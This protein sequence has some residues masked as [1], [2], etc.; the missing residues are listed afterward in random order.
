MTIISSLLRFNQ[1]FSLKLTF[2]AL[3]LSVCSCTQVK[4]DNNKTAHIISINEIMASNNSGITAQNGKLYDWIEI[5]NKSDKNVN[6]KDYKLVLEK[7]S[8]KKNN[9][10]QESTT[11][12]SWKCPDKELKPGECAIIF[13]SKK[14]KGDNNKDKDNKAKDNDEEMHA[15]FKLPSEGGKLSILF[16]DTTLVSSVE[17]GPLENDQCYRANVKLDSLF[18][19]S[20][21][22]TPGFDNDENGFE[23]YNS[24]IEHLRQGPL[25]LWELH[26]KGHYDNKAWVEIKNVSN[27]PVNLQDYYLTTSTKDMSRWQLPEVQLQ[28]G[29]VYLVNSKKGIFKISSSKSVM[30]TKDSKFVDGICASNAPAG[31]S[32]GRVTGK[33]GLFYFASP[34][35]GEENN[36]PYYRYI[37]QQPSFNTKPGVY[38]KKDGMLLTLDTHGYT[39][40][41]TTDGSR[42]TKESPV[43][44]D[45]IMINKT[46]IVRAFCEGDSSHIASNTTFGTF[47]IDEAHTIPVINITVDK[48]DLYDHN[49]GIYAEGPGYTPIYPHKGANYWKR[50]WKNAH[51][52]LFDNQGDCD[53][54]SEDCQLAIFGGFSRF[55]P[56]K[57]F[58]IRFKNA[59]GPSHIFYDLF[60]DGNPIKHKNFVLRSGSQDISGTMIR[61]EYFTSLM[62]ENSPNLLTQAYRPAALYINGEYFG[63]YYIREKIDDNYVAR[64]LNVSNDSITIMMSGLYCDQGSKTLYNQ[65]I[66]YVTGHDM[67]QDEFYNQVKDQFDLEGLIDYKLG[68]IYSMKVDAGNVRYVYSPDP[69]GDKKWHVVYYDIDASWGRTSRPM[70]FYVRMEGDRVVRAVNTLTH[71]L[72]KNDNFRQ[73]FLERLSHHMH[74]T[75]TYDN[76]TT[77]FDNLINTI[78]PEMK[79][80]CERWASVMSYNSWEKH[81]ADFRNKFKDRDK[82]VLNGLRHELQITD[83]ENK[84][85]FSDLGF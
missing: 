7:T 78:K 12:I 39:V 79:R 37:A 34:T 48:A 49:R 36:A 32:V 68:E 1:L 61:D 23:Q 72:L 84:K 30:L 74:T 40:H 54:F 29:E 8:S 56:K 50:W 41:Y 67:S 52:E 76:V 22:P 59:N 20:Y 19:K 3:L 33:D 24:A 63:L 71:N 82:D 5:K 70:S 9:N 43:Y 65:L 11:K 10:D 62:Q 85:Y 75:F 16:N 64:H 21:E 81:I 47:I 27:N 77:K 42:P 73:L 4:K 55:L 57:S 53:G 26:S 17:Y 18:E 38:D 83:E 44:H 6:L 58:K 15:N 51:V 66:S 46:T 25:R 31:V 2:V 45:S 69:K 13:A 28:P 80:N 60:A 35:P 14:S